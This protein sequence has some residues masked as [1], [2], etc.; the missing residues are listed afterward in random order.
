MRLVSSLEA[1]NQEGSEFDQVLLILF[2]LQHGLMF[3]L[4]NFQPVVVLG[5]FLFLVAIFYHC[6]FILHERQ[7][8]V[9]EVFLSACECRVK[10]IEMKKILPYSPTLGVLQTV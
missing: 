9:Q 2:Q 5:S 10:R 4:Q 1:G 7:D 3:L 6:E 8:N